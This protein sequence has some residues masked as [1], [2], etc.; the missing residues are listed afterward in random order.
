VTLMT[1]M[2]LIPDYFPAEFVLINR[3]EMGHTVI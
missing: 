1:T 3:K 2:T